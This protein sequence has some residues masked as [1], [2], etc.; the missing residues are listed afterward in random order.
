MYWRSLS[1]LDIQ[2]VNWNSLF[3]SPM[4]C[5]SIPVCEMIISP[6][7]ENLILPHLHY[8]LDFHQRYLLP[9]SFL[10]LLSQAQFRWSRREQSSAR[11]DVYW[12]RHH[13]FQH[14]SHHQMIAV[15]NHRSTSE[16]AKKQAIYIALVISELRFHR[17][18]NDKRTWTADDAAS[19]STIMG[20]FVTCAARSLSIRNRS[21]PC[22]L[23]SF[24]RSALAYGDNWH[25]V[26]IW[27]GRFSDIG[28]SAHLLDLRQEKLY[29]VKNCK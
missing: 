21:F 6:L 3:T 16:I 15:R 5:L 14:P 10:L 23:I 4:L 11:S 24:S 27:N 17:I 13:Q 28:S 9:T 18:K 20:V 25:Q 19:V 8:L 29:S 2:H 12:C 1:R 7:V 26:R 22:R